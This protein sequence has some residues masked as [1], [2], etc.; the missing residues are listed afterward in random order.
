MPVKYIALL[1]ALLMTPLVVLH[2]ADHPMRIELG[3]PETVLADKALGLRYFPDGAMAVVR[4]KPGCRVITAAGVSSVLLEGPEMGRFTKATEVL[5][6]GKPGEFDN[7]YAGINA[8]VR[9]RTGQLLGFYH[10]EDQEGMASVGSGIPGFYCRVALALSLGDGTSF[11]KRGPILSGQLQKDPN[12]RPDQ[13]VGEPSV[14]VE[15]KGEFLYAYYTSHEPVDGRGV[16]ICMARCPTADAANP[17]AWKKFHAG[18]FAEAGLGGKDTPVVT[19]GRQDADAL[20]PHVVFVRGL[21]RFVMIFCLN[22]W[23]EGDKPDRSGI[24]AA[25]SDDGIHWPRERMQQIWK[26]PVIATIGREVAW[27][28]T[29]IPDEDNDTRGWLYYGY[30]ENWGDPLPHKPHYLVRRPIAITGSDP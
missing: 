4:T 11:E 13:G 9:T 21:Q 23:R 30:S 26:V 10:A 15:P 5:K 22:A 24:Y 14:F 27:H 2:A 19:S 29:F 1:T 17:V 20:F 12:G 18:G 3:P 6:K 8:V 16:Q 25:F 7:G 28:P